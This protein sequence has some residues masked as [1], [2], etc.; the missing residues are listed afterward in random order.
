MNGERPPDW[1]ATLVHA[2]VLSPFDRQFAAAMMRLSGETRP[3]LELAAALSS[4]AVAHGHVCLSLGD[5][6]EFLDPASIGSD[7]PADLDPSTW[8]ITWP[9]QLRDSPMVATDVDRQPQRPLVFVEPDRLYLSRYYDHES[10]VASALRE[11]ANATIDNVDSV[12]VDAR[13]DALFADLQSGPARRA[14]DIACRRRLLV[15]A[16]GPGTGKTTT[17]VRLLA[18]LASTRAQP[19]RRIALLAPTGKAV[20]RLEAAVRAGQQR[21]IDAG[22]LTTPLPLRS[23]T[24]HRALRPLGG[25]AL[26]FRHDRDNPLADDVVVVDEASMIDL[27]LTRRLLDAIAQDTTL[28][29]LGD[30]DQLTS[31]EAGAVFGDV[32][33]AGRQLAAVD[34]APAGIGACFSELL[35]SHR[36]S[37]DSGIGALAQAVR[38]G[39]AAAAIAL[40]D[41]PRPAHL[42]WIEPTGSALPRDQ[43]AAMAKLYRAPASA[44][45][46]THLA[47]IEAYRVLA[48]LHGGPRGVDA[49]NEALWRRLAADCVRPILITRNDAGS[50]LFNGDIGVECLE[51]SRRIAYFPNLDPGAPPRRF[52]SARLPA[53]ET[54][55]AMSV[56]K[57]QGS[58]FDHVCIVLPDDDSPLLS[59]ELLY[60]AITRAR[61]HVTLIA[62]RSVLAAMID[63]HVGRASGLTRQ[64]IDSASS[65]ATN[66]I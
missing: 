18:A 65:V 4:R 5:G 20:A 63:R 16:G 55:F 2:G 24:I 14:A 39:D 8:P 15:L 10:T 64:L 3:A 47:Q 66:G 51:G 61:R 31:V 6:P 19:L 60:T 42:T 12:R 36:F 49:I 25:P 13:L 38:S 54:V 29:L 46:D 1:L 52:A 23:A 62:S 43:L 33:A 34:E 37:A 17:A 57:S 22:Q 26:G 35:H 45:A 59:R 50:N 30:P 27:A 53:H 44:S 9:D 32:C 56:H 40:L 21:L 11:R 58:E 28:V 41:A 48:P 7:R